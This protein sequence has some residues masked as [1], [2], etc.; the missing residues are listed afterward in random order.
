MSIY[1]DHGKA[2]HIS[3]LWAGVAAAERAADTYKK[4]PFMRELVARQ[5]KLAARLRQKAR[6]LQGAS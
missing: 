1:T 2:V 3:R 5:L 6:E 4:F